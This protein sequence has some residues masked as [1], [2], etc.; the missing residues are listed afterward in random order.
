MFCG[1]VQRSRWCL[2]STLL[3]SRRR[4]HLHPFHVHLPCE[5]VAWC[6]SGFSL[7][8]PCS[9]PAVLRVEKCGAIIITTPSLIELQSHEGVPPHFRRLKLLVTRT[10]SF[11]PIFSFFSST[12]H[13][14]AAT[15]ESTPIRKM[16]G[17]F[18]E[19]DIVVLESLCSTEK[20]TGTTREKTRT[21]R[22]ETGR[23]VQHTRPGPT[24]LLRFR[25]LFDLLTRKLPLSGLR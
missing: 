3:P 9:C 12:T 18:K 19:D 25:F 6:V 13:G 14:S 17:D 10:H 4:T 7:S 23:G 1:T 8:V 5:T 20:R 15:G 2:H 21:H 22:T 11:V 16:V 24:K